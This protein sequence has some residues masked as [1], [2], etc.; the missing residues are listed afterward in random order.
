MT[1][2]KSCWEKIEKEVLPVYSEFKTGGES[3]EEIVK[4]LTSELEKLNGKFKIISIAHLEELR[5][6]IAGLRREG[7]M[8]EKF[9]S[10]ILSFFKFDKFHVLPN[11]KSII[12]IA[13]PQ[14][15]T[16]VDFRRQGKHHW[17]VVPPTY[18]Y[19]WIRNACTAILSEIFGATGNKVAGAFLPLKLL[20][21]RSGL[22][23][24][25][26]NN[27]CYVDGMGSFHRLEAFYT[28]YPFRVDSWQEKE[29]M[30]SC[31]NC[32]LCL[33]ACPTRCISS[34][35]FLIN[36]EICLTHFN[37][38]EGNF[39]RWIDPKSHNAIVGCMRCQIACP[40]NREFLSGKE[41]S[42]TFSEE[43]TEIILKET[44][45]D[46]LPDE[47]SAKLKRLNM[48]EYYSL[49]PRNL[50]VLAKRW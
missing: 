30:D 50:A 36:A 48:Y 49:L 29:M 43:E 46:S 3:V 32:S 40:V 44:P 31:T 26:R 19:S 5:D 23:K 6:E 1:R 38:N 45:K 14:G 28:D 13:I 42:E 15:M 41:T 11:A 39:P 25:G 27:I 18:I 9:Y 24:Y 7:K 8:S 33:E 16:L 12:L 47:L 4:T 20:A 22:G 10:E 34:E 17:V 37:E 35:T 21:V 2:A